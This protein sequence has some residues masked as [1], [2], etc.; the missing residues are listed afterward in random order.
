MIPA[1]I[2]AISARTITDLLI[3]EAEHKPIPHFA[4]PIALPAQERTMPH[5]IPKKPMNGVH[6]G[7]TV[8]SSAKDIERAMVN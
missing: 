8:S 7:H 5:K 3:T 4:V 6:A 1:I 2:G